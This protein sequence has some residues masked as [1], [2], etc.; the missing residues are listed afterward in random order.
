MLLKAYN[1]TE[2]PATRLTITSLLKV[3]LSDSILFQEDPQEVYLWLDS[4]P[5]TQRTVGAEAL[6][7]AMLTDEGDSVID[8]LDDCVQRCL[9]TPHRYLEGRDSLAQSI[10]TESAGSDESIALDHQAVLCSPLLV[11]VLDQLGAKIAG[12]L[13]T[14]SDVLALATFVRK[15]V[16]KLSS[17]QRALDFLLAWTDRFDALLRPD[18][19]PEYPNIMTA[20]RREVPILRL[21]LGH[22][23]VSTSSPAP[24]SVV[25]EFLTNVEQVE[26]RPCSSFPLFGIPSDTYYSRVGSLTCRI[27][28]RALGLGPVD[29]SPT[30]HK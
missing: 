30:A 28:I 1:T 18:L 8:F 14:P 19:F 13:L 16:F 15:L 4:L 23:H 22:T 11:V 2:V 9:K 25:Q 17:K 3:V 24:S 20:I 29:W 7:G 21:Y 10:S 27:G 6:D 12:K 5:A 26:I